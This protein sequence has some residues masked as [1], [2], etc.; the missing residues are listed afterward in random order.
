METITTSGGDSGRDV[1]FNGKGKHDASGEG[2]ATGDQQ[3]DFVVDGHGDDGAVT[4]M[5]YV[6]G[7]VS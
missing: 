3:A 6:P 5:V 7:K 1:A 4:K 2:R